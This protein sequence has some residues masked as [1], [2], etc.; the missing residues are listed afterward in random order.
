MKTYS[1]DESDGVDVNTEKKEYT[2]DPT[3]SNNDLNSASDLAFVNSL[4]ADSDIEFKDDDDDADIKDLLNLSDSE[5]D[6]ET[7]GQPR[8]EEE[9]QKRLKEKRKQSKKNR[10]TF[11]QFFMPKLSA[12]RRAAGLL[13]PLE[14]KVEKKKKSFGEQEEV[15]VAKKTL[16]DDL[17]DGAKEILAY[18]TGEE[19]YEHKKLELSDIPDVLSSVWYT[20]KRRVLI[21]WLGVYTLNLT[22]FKKYY[23]PASKALLL[24]CRSRYVKPFHVADLLEEGADPNIC[25]KDTQCTP[26]H[27]LVRRANLQG[28]KLLCEA[29][30]R[31]LT[32]DAQHRNALMCACD[33]K[34]T[35]DQVRI[36]RY[37][38]NRPE[39]VGA[40]NL[41]HRDTGGNTAAINAI[42]KGNV[43]ILRELLLAGARVTEEDPSLGYKSAH[44]VALWVYAASLLSDI[45]QLPAIALN[46]PE[47]MSCCWKFFSPKGHHYWAFLLLFQSFYKYSNELCF[48]M[49]QNKKQAEDLIQWEP[50]PRRAVLQMSD[51]RAENRKKKREHKER[52]RARKERHDKKLITRKLDHE[53]KEVATWNKQRLM[54]AERIDK[55]FKK[56]KCR[57]NYFV[58]CLSYRSTRKHMVEG[59]SAHQLRRCL[60]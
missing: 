13:P 48:R 8:N 1:D 17:K 45:D 7:G 50:K 47:A 58:H 16:V 31:V 54:M 36:V 56:G 37:L 19:L 20:N 18:F 53:V 28:V 32:F 11:Q 57:L 41:E 22:G 29:G 27:Y 39:H 34:R 5:D 6:V 12:L 3:L 38:L 21:N 26:L 46:K 24:A 35:G 52:E 25:E 33:T 55:E 30:A 42:F 40:K 43:W 44:H 2:T 9:I 15:V 49:C 59:V 51:Q 4:N 14:V 23:K 60:S 10:Y